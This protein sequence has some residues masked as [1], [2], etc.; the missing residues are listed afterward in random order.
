MESIETEKDHAREFPKL[1][2]RLCSSLD[3]R[4][5]MSEVKS[6]PLQKRSSL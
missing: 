4:G 3:V 6:H 1:V 2:R 5:Q